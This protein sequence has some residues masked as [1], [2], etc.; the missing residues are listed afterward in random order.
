M[1][2]GSRLECVTSNSILQSTYITVSEYVVLG[3]LPLKGHCDDAWLPS[4]VCRVEL[5]V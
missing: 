1:M 5:S 3:C 2:R 4:R